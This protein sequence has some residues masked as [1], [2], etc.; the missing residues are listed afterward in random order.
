MTYTDFVRSVESTSW[1]QP[2]ERLLHA[3]MGLCTETGELYEVE[4]D[5][6]EIE[7]VGDIC[8][9]LA[10]A[11]DSL[12]ASFEEAPILSEEAFVKQVRGEEGVESLTIYATEL[13]DLVKKQVFYGRQIDRNTAIDLLVMMKNIIHFGLELGDS[14]LT[15]QAVLDANV[16]KLKTR[17]PEK[18]S[19]EAAVNRNVDAEY[20]NMMSASS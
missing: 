10:L 20:R 12:G 7:E 18:F 9:Y 13:L 6:H 4:S 1:H 19:E 15:L 8:W 2:N 3:A 16:R 14:D 11:F 5:Q 17:Y